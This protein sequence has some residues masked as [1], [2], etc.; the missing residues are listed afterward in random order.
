MFWN[1]LKRLQMYHYFT[2]QEIMTPI[3]YLLP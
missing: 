3:V 1:K 2:S